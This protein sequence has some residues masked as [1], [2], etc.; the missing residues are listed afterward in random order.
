MFHRHLE[1]PNDA[2]SGHLRAVLAGFLVQ[3]HS[4]DDPFIPIA[5]ARHVAESL[6]S[7]CDYIEHTPRGLVA[8][9]ES[10][11]GGLRTSLTGSVLEMSC[12]RSWRNCSCR[13]PKGPKLARKGGGLDGSCPKRQAV[14]INN[15][16]WGLH[17]P[18]EAGKA[19]KGLLQVCC[20][21]YGAL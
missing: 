5:E 4:L 10:I 18:I 20:K 21:L 16:Q 17:G 14:Y 9:K 19:Y 2:S 3:F 6:G 8:C 7:K 11:L 15:C 1:P 13:L 12:L